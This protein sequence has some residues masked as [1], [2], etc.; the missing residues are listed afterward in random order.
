MLNIGKYTFE[1]RLLLGTGK[2]SDLEVQS[3]AVEASETEVLTF[4]VRRLNLEERNQRAFPGYVGSGPIHASSEYSW[5]FH[6]GRG[7]A[8]CRACAGFGTL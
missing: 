6:C 2:F 4:A 5:G 1:S 8:N 7:G 3:Q